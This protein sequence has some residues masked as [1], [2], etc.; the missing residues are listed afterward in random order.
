MNMSVNQVEQEVHKNK[1]VEHKLIH[2]K[3]DQAQQIV[4]LNLHE[5][6]IIEESSKVC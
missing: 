1:P 3:Q 5:L 6:Q 4:G 2:N